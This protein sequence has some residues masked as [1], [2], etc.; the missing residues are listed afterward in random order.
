MR[1]LTHALSAWQTCRTLPR[2]ALGAAEPWLK[3]SGI[4]CKLGEVLEAAHLPHKAYDV[5]AECLA[6]MQA[7]AA[8]NELS[9]AERHRAVALA[10]H[11]GA[12]ADQLQRFD[13]EEK[14]L[15]WSVEELLR[16]NAAHTTSTHAAEL[17]LPEWT[18]N[19]DL[20]AA[21][22]TLGSFYAKTGKIEYVPPPPHR[23]A[24]TPPPTA[25]RSP[26]TST[27]SPQY[28]PTTPPPPHPPPR[29]ASA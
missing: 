1:R 5:Y 17:N 11:L 15:S 14:F 21:L 2:E 6:L 27:P 3:I 23:A 8:R 7:S 18:S 10:I 9:R 29:T 24:L 25:T 20:G 4:A 26:S 19:D 16:A 13:D 22:E 28:C 12:L